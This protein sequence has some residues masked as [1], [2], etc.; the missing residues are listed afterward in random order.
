MLCSDISHMAL[1][2]VWRDSGVT[3]KHGFD[4]SVHMANVEAP[5]QPFVQMSERGPKLLDGAYDFL[6]GLHH[7]TYIYRARGDKRFMYLAQAQNDWDDRLIAVDGIN[8]P[9]DLHGKK[10]VVTSTAPCVMGNMK[11]SL[12]AGGADLDK[13]EFVVLDG[14]KNFV[15]RYAVEEVA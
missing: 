13:I 1:L 11:H 7:E 15:C 10:M 2:Y 6:S 3:Q 14:P 12:Q 9:S 4:L 5:G 8:A